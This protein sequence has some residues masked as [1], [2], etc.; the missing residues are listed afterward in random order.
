MKYEFKTPVLSQEQLLN[1][2]NPDV[3]W[4]QAWLNANCGTKLEVDGVW[5][6]SSR[7]EFIHAMTNRNAS[8][9]L[10]RE[11]LSIAKDLGDTN[12]KRIK[13]VA[14]VESGGSGGWF[15]SGLPKILYER[16]KF[17]E[18]TTNVS[19]HICLSLTVFFYVTASVV[20]LR[21]GTDHE[22]IGKYVSQHDIRGTR[23]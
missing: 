7:A 20:K 13:A 11:L 5:G 12:T 8:P 18:W 19:K 1:V 17:W 21:I 14:V 9:I 6:T 15:N 10:P 4:I 23:S 22:R 3:A 16:H 2:R